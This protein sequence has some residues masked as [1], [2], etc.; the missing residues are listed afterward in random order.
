MNHR[1]LFFFLAMS[2]VVPIQAGHAAPP[3]SNRPIVQ[4]NFLQLM[5]TNACSGCDLAGADLTRVK[6]AGADLEGA[7]LAGV[8]FVLADLSGANLRNAN[9]QGANLGGADLANANLEGAN[10]TG[11]FLEGAF[12]ATAKMT[13]SI[14]TRPGRA[15]E[16]AQGVGE[17]VFVPDVT[18]PKSKPYT[19]ELII[20]QPA[21]QSTVDTPALQADPLT[22]SSPETASVSSPPQEVPEPPVGRRPI[23]PLV[24]P[25][26]DPVQTKKI[27]PIA[28]AD[29]PTEVHAVSSADAPV[30]EQIEDPSSTGKQASASHAGSPDSTPAGT[31]IPD[32]P[33]VLSSGTRMEAAYFEAGEEF[34]A[35]AASGANEP[36]TRAVDVEADFSHSATTQ[37]IALPESQPEK[38]VLSQ[39]EPAPT[40][41]FSSARQEPNV[42][43]PALSPG[44]GGEDLIQIAA[45]AAD[46]GKQELLDRLFKDKR[47]VGCDLSQVDLAGK[48]LS[49]FDLER[50]DLS[51]SDLRRARLGRA[52][53]KGAN[54]RQANLQ[55]ADLR[56]A[57]LYLA[58]FTRADL[59]GARLENALVDG[60]VFTGALGLDLEGALV[61]E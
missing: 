51:G 44:E 61:A 58:D 56:R 9:L 35:V 54:L 48:N 46:T 17:K 3:G 32:E 14:Q 43:S 59:T 31:E 25:M 53:L 50:A 30:P 52:N 1:V 2:M 40:S 20:E 38:E 15:A 23:A 18:Q 28:D 27:V 19:Q 42:F 7:N 13:G 55:D 34:F 47:C 29:I 36:G 45:V 33:E 22:S 6:L 57:D 10:L 49:G 16:V 26:V 4:E 24:Q 60:A 21:D 11:A 41:D 8:K 5:A 12:L 37:K 39:E